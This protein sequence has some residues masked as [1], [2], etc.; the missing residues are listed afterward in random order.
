MM[1][2]RLQGEVTGLEPVGLRNYGNTCFLN[3]TLQSLAHCELLT[4]LLRR[5]IDTNPEHFHHSSKETNE[6][7][8]CIIEKCLLSLQGSPVFH[9]DESAAAQETALRAD[10]FVK[11]L[12][13]SFPVFPT[14]TLLRGRQEDAHEFLMNVV[15][16]Y[17]SPNKP[18]HRGVADLFEGS[19]ASYIYCFQCRNV[20]K[21]VELING[22]ELQINGINTLHT[23]IREY[24]R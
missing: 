9:L 14:K 23:A 21:K 20:T 4:S 15:Q 10:R 11:Q 12:I 8:L 16:A 3:A 24:C 17:R 13:Y 7:L 18:F 19:A 22:L 1:M 2:E 5:E 6:C